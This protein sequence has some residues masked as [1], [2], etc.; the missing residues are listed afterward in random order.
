LPKKTPAGKESILATALTSMVRSTTEQLPRHRA[1]S[2]LPMSR[3]PGIQ[4]PLSSHLRSPFISQE[5]LSLILWEILMIF[6]NNALRSFSP[7]T[8][9]SFQKV[10]KAQ[11]IMK[12]IGKLWAIRKVEF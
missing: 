12:V 3:C 10:Q 11:E 8:L 2:T 9:I 4:P 5:S 1:L 7:P 6:S